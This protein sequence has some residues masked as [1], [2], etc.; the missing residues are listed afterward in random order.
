V[1]PKELMKV[2]LIA[3]NIIVNFELWKLLKAIS[4][5]CKIVNF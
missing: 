4:T 1:L 3:S 5:K 2:I